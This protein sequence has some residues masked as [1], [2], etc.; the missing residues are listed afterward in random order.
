MLG[1]M[2]FLWYF[3]QINLLNQLTL[4]IQVIARADCEVWFLSR[5]SF[6]NILNAHPQKAAYLRTMHTAFI[7]VPAVL[8]RQQ[9]LNVSVN[10]STSISASL[11][12]RAMFRSNPARRGNEIVHAT[13]VQAFTQRLQETSQRKALIIHP[14]G[15]VGICWTFLLTLVTMYNFIVIPLRIAYFQGCHADAYFIF[16]YAGDALY[17]TDIVLRMFCIAYYE[18]DDLVEVRSKIRANYIKTGRVYGD[19]LSVLPFDLIALAGPLGTLGVA[20]V[21]SLFR[22]NRLIRLRDANS[23]FK[24]LET[25]VTKWLKSKS[26]SQKNA[27]RL[28]KLIVTIFLIAHMFGCCFFMVANQLHLSGDA[29]N[30]AEKAGLFALPATTDHA[31]WSMQPTSA[32]VFTQYVASIYWAIAL[33]TTV[34]Y[35]DISP[36]NDWEKAYNIVLFV[37]GT[38]VYAMVIV[39]LQDIVSELDV[40]SDIF[41]GRVGK[42]QAFLSREAVGPEFNLK[43]RGYMDRLWSAQRGAR[44]DEIQAFMPAPLYCATVNSCVSKHLP[45]LFFVHKCHA[46]FQRAFLSRLRV[47]HYIK[48]EH[49]FRTSEAAQKLYFIAQGEVS[50]VSMDLQTDT[51]TSLDAPIMKKR[52]SLLSTFGTRR[53]SLQGLVKAPAATAPPLSVKLSPPPFDGVQPKRFSLL[54]LRPR[55]SLISNLPMDAPGGP[56][57]VTSQF[58][59]KAGNKRTSYLKVHDGF[60]G[61]MEFF[62]RACY[63]C[64]AKTN[65]DTILLEMEFSEFWA[66]V[67]YFNLQA[68]YAKVLKRD[69]AG[70][71]HNSTLSVVQKLDTNMANKKMARMMS[72]CVVEAP[73]VHSIAP[74]AFSAQIWN[75]L[76]LTMLLLMAICVPYFTAFPR[77]CSVVLQLALDSLVTV[78]FSIDMYL[79]MHIFAVLDDGVTISEP[80]SICAHY[81]THYFQLDA[82]A[83]FPVALLVFAASQD[84]VAYGACRWLFLLRLNKASFL[85]DSVVNSVFASA[86]QTASE[87]MK[88]VFA[89][90]LGV[91]YIAHVA[92]CLFCT[93]GRLELQSGRESWLSANDWD[94]GADVSIYLRS[95]YWALYTLTTV[96][97]GSV[98]VPTNT[99]RLFAIGVMIMGSI[100][101]AMLSA[102]LSSM[103]ESSDQSRGLIR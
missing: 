81:M 89:A 20:Q 10:L 90:V 30:W 67:L 35:G 41:K 98:A 32:Q 26:R 93:V 31:A 70:L 25:S 33:L 17:L 4:I 55:T 66:L 74:D 94:S 63:S 45:Q 68:Q 92:G 24:M 48:D 101:N 8:A 50:L 79:R 22:I 84:P 12:G 11:N 42:L 87:G 72:V 21:L 54:S 28:V 7:K 38:L 18:R 73:Q 9:S 97:Y 71:H 51:N 65:S 6:E 76:T 13:D 47:V 56:S 99:E 102:L 86:G 57:A 44:S 43:V 62:T 85:L 36:V 61:E 83:T 75:V 23:G 80:S 2:L 58:Q 59:R 19:V 37:I 53:I 103:V 95:Y 39:H 100:L 15:L 64:S 40:T 46:A 1:R 5:T 88:R 77:I 49:V 82:A 29:E 27:I 34:G 69:G 52:N 96:G 14:D 16:D 78:V 91:L 60:I 3:L